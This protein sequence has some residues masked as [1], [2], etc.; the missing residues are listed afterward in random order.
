MCVINPACAEKSLQRIVSWDHETSKVDQ[1]C[2]TDVEE[3][4]EE[5]E[6]NQTEEGIG[7]RNVGLLLEIV[8]GRILRQLEAQKSAKRRRSVQT[9]RLEPLHIVV[10]RNSWCRLR[11]CDIG[12]V[13]CARTSRQITRWDTHVFVELIEIV[14]SFVLEGHFDGGMNGLGGV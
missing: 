7:F 12:V 9:Q 14:L 5:V 6:A 2:T 10:F 4:E 11:A 3:D 8:E 13:T 1:E